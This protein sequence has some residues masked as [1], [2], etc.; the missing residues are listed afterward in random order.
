MEFIPNIFDFNQYG[1]KIDLKDDY[2]EFKVDFIEQQI[3]E[4]IKKLKLENKSN[5]NIIKLLENIG[6]NV[7]NEE[8]SGLELMHIYFAYQNRSYIG[9]HNIHKTIPKI[10]NVPIKLFNPN[11][12]YK[13]DLIKC[14]IENNIDINYAN[15]VNSHLKINNILNKDVKTELI[16]GKSKL[17][18]FKKFYHLSINQDK[19]NV[20]LC[21]IQNTLIAI[22]F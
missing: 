12:V 8:W 14:Y 4:L 9:I 15:E 13:I 20:K 2:I 11:N 10:I 3:I 7:R 1:F 6:L 21:I 5:I 19:K 16:I 18:E 17:S 22:L